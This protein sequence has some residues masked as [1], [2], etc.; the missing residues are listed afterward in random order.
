M[1][2]P[3][4]LLWIE[5]AMN[6]SALLVAIGVSGEFI[7]SWVANPI[8]KRIDAANQRE[9]T[10]LQIE[11]AD[12]KHRQAE[13]EKQ[14]EEV[15]KRQEPRGVRVGD[16]ASALKKFPPGKA[17]LEYQEGN[18]E[19]YLFT[20]TLRQAL[21]AGGWDISEPIAVRSIADK[22]GA[23]LAEIVFVKRDL[24]DGS[25]DILCV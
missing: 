23:A 11:A 7:G 13:A 4:K 8:R 18:P 20:S 12:A 5:R 22:K 1:D 10:I 3:T 9:I 16:I 2:D 15:K 24:S 17:I 6:V 14:L 25:K 21:I 19:T